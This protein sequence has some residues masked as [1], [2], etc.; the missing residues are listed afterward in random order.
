MARDK[1]EKH[2]LLSK[3]LRLLTVAVNRLFDFKEKVISGTCPPPDVSPDDNVVP[4]EQVL[5][6]A[7]EKIIIE[8]TKIIQI[9]EQLEASL[10]DAKKE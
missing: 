10:F 3:Q 2:I 4:L 5:S 8:H 1:L 6:E 7:P 9:I